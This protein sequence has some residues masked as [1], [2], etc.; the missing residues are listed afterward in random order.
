MI[1]SAL[2]KAKILVVVCTNPDYVQKGWVNYEWDSFS[3]D[4]LSDIKPDGKIFSYIDKVN[5]HDLP[6][7]LRQQQVFVE[8]EN[9]LD[10]ICSYII[11]AL[12]N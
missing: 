1:D 12:K 11:N 6:R 2:D 9:S 10:D 3:N 7:T 4:I 5:I 8:K